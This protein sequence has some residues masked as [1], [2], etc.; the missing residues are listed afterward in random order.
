M[1]SK[2]S[3]SIR[4]SCV[5]ACLLSTKT[6]RFG[7]TLDELIPTPNAQDNRAEGWVEL[8]IGYETRKGQTA[9]VHPLVMRRDI[10]RGR[11]ENQMPNSH[12]KPR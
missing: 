5:A 1:K 7:I 6:Q 11:F 12:E 2:Q 3:V 10:S 9:P 8:V 4:V